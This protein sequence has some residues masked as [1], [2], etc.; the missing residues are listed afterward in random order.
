MPLF[1][2]TFLV[3]VPR[4][5][6]IIGMVIGL[7]RLDVSPLPESVVGILAYLLHFLITFLCALWA[8]RGAG[9]SWG[10]IFGVAGVFL[11]VGTGWEMGLYAWMTKSSIWEM[12]Q[13]LGLQ[14]LYLL[15]IYFVAV[16]CAGAYNRGRV[17]RVEI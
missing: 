1:L 17:A 3:T 10:Q 6:L 11:V 5:I 16:L 14:S 12:V 13:N 2:R 4:F 7:N 8:M 9:R 15:V